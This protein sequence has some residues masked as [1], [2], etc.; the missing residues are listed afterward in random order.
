[1]SPG[2][3]LCIAVAGVDKECFPLCKYCVL[4]MIRSSHEQD[5]VITQLFQTIEA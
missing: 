3:S 4:V 1:M 5:Q 2:T